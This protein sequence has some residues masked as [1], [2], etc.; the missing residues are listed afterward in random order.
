MGLTAMR[1]I[2]LFVGLLIQSLS[3]A[4]VTNDQASF[5]VEKYGK[6]N[7]QHPLVQQAQN[8]FKQVSSVA[9]KNAQRLP[10]LVVINNLAEPLAFALPDGSIVIAQKAIELSYQNVEKKQGDAR[11]AFILGHELAHLANNDFW[12]REVMNFVQNSNELQ[13]SLSTMSLQDIQGRELAADDKGFL[14]AATAG[15]AVDLLLS[16]KENSN[17][18]VFWEKQ[19]PQTLAN[20][21]NVA[22]AANVLK[23]THPD[24]NTRAALLQ[25]RL[26]QWWDK[27][28]F[29]NFG[30]RLAHFQRCDDALYF[31]RDFQ[32]TFPSREVFN[33]LGYCY[34]QL[35]YKNK[36]AQ[37]YH[38]W[39][40][41][42]LDLLSR[43]EALT[44]VPSAKRG[45]LLDNTTQEYL[46][47]ANQYFELA[48]RA[49]PFYVP[50]WVNL[51]ISNLQRE[52]IFAAR[53]AIERAR[54][55][56]PD[57]VDIQGIR[58]VILY[59]E[60]QEMDTWSNAMTLLQQLSQQANVTPS[61]L[62]NTAQLLEERGRTG[63]AFLWQQLQ[64]HLTETPTVL[65]AVICQKVEESARTQNCKDILKVHAAKN[66]PLPE[67]A[68]KLPI[69]AGMYVKREP[70]VQAQLQKW[71][72]QPFD[73]QSEIYG[74]LYR[75]P[76][77]QIEALELAGYLELVVLKNPNLSLNQLKAMCTTG[78]KA[79]PAVAATLWNCQSWTFVE[80][81]N[82]V[83]EVWLNA[84]E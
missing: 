80:V 31:L 2:F 72:K 16:E 61:I 79:V 20:I 14:Y 63:S 11:L 5:F 84:M 73:W 82:K 43:A 56:E 23:S 55:L 66:N 35:A 67:F 7:T 1:R 52:E 77:A 32:R 83:K 25:E 38:Y 48:T 81:D 76:D 42:Q 21:N 40:P 10:Q 22:Q 51:A 4:Q 78:L 53:N 58:A 28:S 17:F 24:A 15:F 62:Y 70:I 34:L 60:G 27:L 57:N 19:L 8:V 68:K 39:L 6:A 71:Q 46:N 49:D 41:T 18:L 29:F 59:V 37:A 64:Q 47:Q 13:N 54:K 12:H 44:A 65:Q 74:A 45:M 75:S 26:K 9:D 30:V 3:Y 33:N 50:S 36:G 69:Q